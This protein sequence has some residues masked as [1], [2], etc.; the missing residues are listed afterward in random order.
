MTIPD[1]ARCPLCGQPN[2]CAMEIAKA[3]G[4][5]QAP[6]WCAQVRIDPAALAALPPPAWGRACLCRACATSSHRPQTQ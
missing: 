1:S 6:C 2:N 3:T 5:P 4:Q